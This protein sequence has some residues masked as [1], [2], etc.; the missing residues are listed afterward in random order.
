MDWTEQDEEKLENK[1]SLSEKRELA[2]DFDT[3]EE[4]L[5]QKLNE[6]G[7]RTLED[8]S[9]KNEKKD[10]L[11]LSYELS[12]MEHRKLQ[13]I[14]GE[15]VAVFVKGKLER[16]IEDSLPS[17]WSLHQGVKL[18]TKNEKSEKSLWF[19][20]KNTLEKGIDISDSTVRHR[21]LSQDKIM[22]AVRD[23]HL[24][25]SDDLFEKFQE[26]RIPNIDQVYYAVKMTGESRDKIYHCVNSEA[27]SFSNQEKLTIPLDEVE[28]FKVIGIEIKTTE[29][30]AESLLSSLQR[31]IRNK[32][33]QSPFL[34]I[35][36]LKV[37]YEKGSREIPED[38]DLRLEKLG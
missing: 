37:E 33:K 24:Y 30:K 23:R 19:G 5:D 28:D 25:C 29:E 4:E 2:K 14:F 35:Y 13:G 26:H 21:N 7:F 8:F 10:T 27:S 3:S 15:K 6:L 18:R 1:F 20:R 12:E 16:F 22:E 31:N 34:D 32:A 38:V 9:N 11:D 17:G 36:S